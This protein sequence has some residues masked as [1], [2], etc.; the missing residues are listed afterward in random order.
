MTDNGWNIT[1]NSGNPVIGINNKGDITGGNLQWIELDVSG[2][3]SFD[4]SDPYSPYDEWVGDLFVDIDADD[5]FDYFIAGEKHHDAM[6]G[7]VY[8]LDNVSARK[9]DS[10]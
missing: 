4:G 5:D 2:G 8:F 3:T 6:P 1:E 9:T 10:S 7:D